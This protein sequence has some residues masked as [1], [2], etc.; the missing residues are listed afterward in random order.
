MWIFLAL[1]MPP[2]GEVHESRSDAELLLEFQRT[3]DAQLVLLLL[4]RYQAGLVARYRRYAHDALTAQ[5]VVNELLLLFFE[6]L[7]RVK[8]PRNVRGLLFTIV[9][10]HLIDLDRRHKLHGNWEEKEK[11]T[12]QEE[13]KSLMWRKDRLSS[14]IDQEAFRTLVISKLNELEWQC[15]EPYLYGKSYKEIGEELD[16]TFNQVRGAINRGLQKLRND[17]E[18][19]RFFD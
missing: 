9:Q 6:R 16:L 4:R 17:P 19:Q 12:Q 1:A 13:G 5:E 2:G 14:R 18:V 3:Q 8:E 11:E 10:N 7:Q 15:L